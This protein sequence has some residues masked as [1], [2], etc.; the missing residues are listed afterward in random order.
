MSSTTDTPCLRHRTVARALGRHAGEL[1]L[2]GV[3]RLAPTPAAGLAR[4]AH[5]LV[6]GGLRE[7]S[8]RAVATLLA[9]SAIDLP[10]R[11]TIAAPAAGPGGGA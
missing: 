11:R 7:A 6:L 8:G 9:N 4:H 1:S 2:A 5:K 3:R 10:Q